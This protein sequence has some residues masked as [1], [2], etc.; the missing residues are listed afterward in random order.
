L[1]QPAKIEVRKILSKNSLVLSDFWISQ[2]FK[3]PFSYGFSYVFPISHGFSYGLRQWNLLGYPWR[4]QT[5]RILPGDLQRRPIDAR[6]QAVPEG[7]HLAA[8]IEGLHHHSLRGR[9]GGTW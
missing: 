1:Q 4:L 5:L 7:P 2:C 6:H 3:P 9:H 8:V